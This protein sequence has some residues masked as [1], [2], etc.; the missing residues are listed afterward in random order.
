MPEN[1][2][3][4]RIFNTL[5]TG[6][7]VLQV[8]SISASIAVSSIAFG[9]WMGLWI[10]QLIVFRKEPA[11]I[12]LLN[13]IRI[14]VF[15][16]AFYCIAELVSR[17]FAVYPEG[18]LTGMKR[19]LLFFIMFAAMFKIP[20]RKA[21]H[22]ILFL[23]ILSVSIVSIF[24]LVKYFISAPVLIP[25]RGFGETR[26]D[27]LS[28]PLTAGEIKIMVLMSVL[29]LLFINERFFLR[30][31]YLAVICAPI[32]LSM[33]LTQ[34]RNVYLAL[35]VCLIIFGFIKNW[36]V[37]LIGGAV[38]AVLLF[39]LP[40]EYTSRFTSIFDS[41]HGSNAGRLT[42]W[43]TGWKMFLANPVI[44]VGDNSIMEVYM[45]YKYPLSDW[46]HS[47]LHSNIFMILVT[48]GILG[49]IGF[50]G[51]FISIFIKQLKY[52]NSFKNESDCALLMGSILVFIAF[53][54][55]GVFEWSF[56]DHEVI[57]V[58]FFLLSVPFVIFKLN[59]KIRR[60]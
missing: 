57:T 24:E 36:K 6:F 19:M 33:L 26:I 22:F 5:I 27:Y 35:A 49:F 39:V 23:I 14:I 1:N 8:I 54:V 21:L 11:A 59:E 18:A 16:A 29:P 46:E 58:L 4:Y 60:H 15:F 10:I 3:N 43:A 34:S 53:H 45:Q 12:A 44:G 55:S 20:D 56:G 13:E 32:F 28:Y 17:V 48:T 9:I 7:L 40:A 37:L 25:E 52:Y 31:R 2:K 50:A 41:S 42:L 30:K 38:F 51:F 47:H